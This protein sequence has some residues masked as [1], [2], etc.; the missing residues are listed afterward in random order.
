MTIRL[1]TDEPKTIKSHHFLE[2]LKLQ[3]RRHPTVIPSVEPAR[4]PVDRPGQLG[5]DESTVGLIIKGAQASAAVLALIYTVVRNHLQDARAEE[6]HAPKLGAARARSGPDPVW[7]VS[8]RG[9]GSWTVTREGELEAVVA[10]LART[11]EG[12][13]AEIVIKRL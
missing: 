1:T 6:Q 2:E 3:L 7:L 11:P 5:V 12:G 10:A 9:Q 13:E 8:A 4:E